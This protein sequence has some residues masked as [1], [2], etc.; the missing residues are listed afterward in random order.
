M[1]SPPLDSAVVGGLSIRFSPNGGLLAIGCTDGGIHLFDASQR[2]APLG[3]LVAAGGGAAHSA[4]VM[5]LDWAADCTRLRSSCAA[6]HVCRWVATARQPVAASED[7]VEKWTTSTVSTA[8]DT[9]GIWPA[10]EQR[11]AVTA[12]DRSPEGDALICGD[13][14]GTLCVFRWPAPGLPGAGHRRYRGHSSAVAA[15]AF[16]WDDR[17]VFSLS[18][19]GGC[20][21]WRHWNQVGER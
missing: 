14:S 5:A 1:G 17:F 11:G 19:D 6:G 18:E 12:V 2:F 16:S 21:V 20:L 10:D 8:W 7:N 15:V 4:G 13:T 9:Q 3:E